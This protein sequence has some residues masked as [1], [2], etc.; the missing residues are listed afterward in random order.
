MNDKLL[1]KRLRT[2]ERVMKRRAKEKEGY[3]PKKRGRPAKKTS[4]EDE[5]LF[6]PIA[7]SYYD[8]QDEFKILT[9]G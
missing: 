3:K 9:K 4:T 6:A 1:D 8:V 5:I 2:I 7:P